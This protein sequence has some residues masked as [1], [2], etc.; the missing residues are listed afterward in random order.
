MAAVTKISAKDVF[1]PN[2]LG[3]LSVV[4]NGREFSIIDERNESCAVERFNLSKELRD[5]T[6]D[7]LQRCLG[8]AYL[9]LNKFG[10]EYS[11]KLNGR[12]PGGGPL[13]GSIGYW[14]VKSVCY[15]TAAAAA[16][17]AIVATGGA[18]AGPVG[19]ALA[20]GGLATAELATGTSFVAGAIATH[21][22]ATALATEVT[23]AAIG[24]GNVAGVIAAVESASAFVGAF[25]TALP[26][27]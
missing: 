22:G 6:N 11:L 18:V 15:G 16:G 2:E 1:I 26:T 13:L 20:G 21:A 9:T 8:A 17:T 3:N 7:Q 4:F 14:V 25:L 23:V 19:A 27:P 12:L 24:T 10:D 5:I